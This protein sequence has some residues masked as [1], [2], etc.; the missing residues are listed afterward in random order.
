[1]AFTNLFV[2]DVEIQNY[3]VI[4]NYFFE[5][6]L[7]M[8]HLSSFFYNLSTIQIPAALRVIILLAWQSSLPVLTFW[9]SQHLQ[10]YAWKRFKRW[11]NNFSCITQGRRSTRQDNETSTGVIYVNG[12]NQEI[13]TDGQ[14]DVSRIKFKS[15]VRNVSLTQNIQTKH[16]NSASYAYTI[17]KNTLSKIEI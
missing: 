11:L 9:R 13:G 5:P 1:M 7:H 3:S 15:H 10:D 17:S 12:K 16:V 4:L 2:K 6:G 14:R 8:S